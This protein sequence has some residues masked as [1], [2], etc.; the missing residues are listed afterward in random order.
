MNM[1]KKIEGWWLDMG[2]V[3]MFWDGGIPAPNK[4]DRMATLVVHEGQHERA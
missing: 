2:T 4:E 3:Q 1:A